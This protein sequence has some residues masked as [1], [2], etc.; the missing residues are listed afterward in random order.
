[1]NDFY[2]RRLDGNPLICNCNLK[3]FIEF[4][5]NDATS[6]HLAATCSSPSKF[7]KKH[8]KLITN[9]DIQCGK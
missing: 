7:E 8:I 5:Y 1:M 6:I 2:C 4:A 9:E 3:W